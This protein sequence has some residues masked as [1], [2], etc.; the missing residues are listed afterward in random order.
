[1][2]QV[3]R[4][5]L[6]GEQIRRPFVVARQFSDFTKVAIMRPLGPAQQ[7][8]ILAHL[9][10]KRQSGLLVRF[11]LVLDIIQPFNRNQKVNNEPTDL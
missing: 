8:Q 9:L 2:E 4:D 5:L 7:L 10:P 3:V 6:L 1:M 11:I